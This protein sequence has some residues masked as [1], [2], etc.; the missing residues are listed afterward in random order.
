MSQKKE[1]M[2]EVE[3]KYF[4]IRKYVQ[5][6]REKGYRPMEAYSIA[7]AKFYI[8]EERVRQIVAKRHCKE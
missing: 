5:E 6:L 8:G 4:A 1:I 2:R 3:K 7:G